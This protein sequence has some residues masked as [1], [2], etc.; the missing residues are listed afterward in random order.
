MLILYY[1]QVLLRLKSVESF[2]EAI[3]ISERAQGKKPFRE[4]S[5]LSL[6]AEKVFLQQME[7]IR[8]KYPLSLQR[9]RA[10]Q[11]GNSSCK[12]KIIVELLLFN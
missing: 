3:A 11:S 9:M 6:I 1:M 2:N 8:L 12:L 10:E 5:A 7:I 4:G